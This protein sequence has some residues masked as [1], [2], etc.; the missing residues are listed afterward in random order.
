MLRQAGDIDAEFENSL[1][2][3]AHFNSTT[4]NH[5]HRKCHQLVQQFSDELASISQSCLQ[6]SAP[7][8]V[9]EVF[10]GPQSEL[11]KQVNNLGFRACRHDFQEGDLATAAGRAVLFTKLV[12]REP[13]SL[14]Y[15]PTCGPWC[16]WSAMN[17]AQTEAGFKTTQNQREQHVFQL[18][19][20]IALFRF[21]QSHGRHMHWE[22]PARS[23]MTR[24]PMLRQVSS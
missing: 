16:A 22:H 4:P 11:T 1:E 20:G 12:Q 6:R 13:R 2:A 24:S 23:V 10:C 5:L 9:L 3:V 14:W 17:A 15:S 18:A 8:Q 7:I 19:L 21:Q